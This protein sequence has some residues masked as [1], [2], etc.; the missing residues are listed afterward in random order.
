M[1][2]ELTVVVKDRYS[3]IQTLLKNCG[4]E[5]CLF[6]CLCSIA[7]EQKGKPIDLI[8]AIKTSLSKGWIDEQFT[9]KNNL[10]VLEYLTGA[11]WDRRHTSSLPV[12]LSVNDYTVAIY[13]N[14]R[15][16][17]RHFRRRGYDTLTNSITVKEG[18]LEG[19]YIYSWS[20]V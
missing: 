10:A 5:G 7:E 11:K 14:K 19:Y 20:Y 1:K 9:V 2:L 12:E 15:T 3:R 13:Y 6:L 8:D 17:Y 18:V 16:G 4:N